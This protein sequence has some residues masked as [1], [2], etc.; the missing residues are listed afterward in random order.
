MC[1]IDLSSRTRRLAGRGTAGRRVLEIDEGEG[2]KPNAARDADLH[3]SRRGGDVQ[4]AV[5]GHEV[6][7]G[8]P[9]GIDRELQLGVEIRGRAEAE[10]PAP[11]P[12]HV[13]LLPH[14][15]PVDVGADVD[16]EELVV[17]DLHSDAMFGG[18]SELAPRVGGGHEESKEDEHARGP[19]DRRERARAG[20]VDS[21]VRHCIRPCTREEN[22]SP[23][24]GAPGSDTLGAR[25]AVRPAEPQ[26]LMPLQAPCF[27][28]LRGS[29]CCRSRCPESG[30]T[31]GRGS[32]RRA[33]CGTRHP[34]RA[35]P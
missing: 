13:E 8:R 33:V 7:L 6:N 23:S 2:G 3:E 29:G 9:D 10:A 5:A 27:V 24:L 20:V 31:S 16:V 35:W 1:G 34:A 18:W 32:D 26:G 28:S 17:P 22:A 12:L 19:A 11:Q 30:S 14:G 25:R 15:D 21:L 4:A